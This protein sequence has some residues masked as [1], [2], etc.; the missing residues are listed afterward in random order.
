MTPQTNTICNNAIVQLWLLVIQREIVLI[1]Q[2]TE[3]GF[4]GVILDNTLVGSK[5]Q[6]VIIY[7]IAILMTIARVIRVK[8]YQYVNGTRMKLL[9]ISVNL[10]LD[11]ILN[12]LD[13]VVV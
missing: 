13:V 3:V 10:Y 9:K 6:I 7:Q 8:V 1:F 4:G 2:S 11:L 5:K 12:R